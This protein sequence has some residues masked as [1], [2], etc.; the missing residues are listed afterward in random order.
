MIHI[1]LAAF[2]A[3]SLT[4]FLITTLFLDNRYKYVM[5]ITK[6]L[7]HSINARHHLQACSPGW[8]CFQNGCL[9]HYHTADSVLNSGCSFI[10]QHI[11]I[12]FCIILAILS[13]WVKSKTFSTGTGCMW[14]HVSGLQIDSLERLSS[15]IATGQGGWRSGQMWRWLESRLSAQV[16]WRCTC[17]YVSPTCLRIL[18]SAIFARKSS[19]HVVW[20]SFAGCLSIAAYTS[21]YPGNPVPR[22]G[23][24][25]TSARGVLIRYC[26][27]SIAAC[28]NSSLAILAIFK[29]RR[30]S[31]CCSCSWPPCLAIVPDTLKTNKKLVA[32]SNNEIRLLPLP[33]T[34]LYPP[35]R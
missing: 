34:L 22:F 26:A 20:R 6:I 5:I 10:S 35:L 17:S 24:V 2:Q 21:L 15:R 13:R 1:V 11:W 29:A 4:F 14:I 7:C 25:R 28:K 9:L 27:S 18:S 32:A 19:S 31:D 16:R 30:M 23:S 33:Y 3:F 12:T 8:S